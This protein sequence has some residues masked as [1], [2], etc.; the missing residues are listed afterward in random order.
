M[1]RSVKGIGSA[2]AKLYRDYRSEEEEGYDSENTIN[3]IEWGFVV[4][5]Y[6]K[7]YLSNQTFFDDSLTIC[8]PQKWERKSEEWIKENFTGETDTI[9][10][11]QD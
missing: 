1:Y 6:E 5:N 4:I 2:M 3:N 9:E 7:L 8:L 11:L 10:L